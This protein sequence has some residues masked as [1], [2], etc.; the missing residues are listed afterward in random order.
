MKRTRLTLAEN[1]DY[2]ENI[3]NFI[4][5][6][7]TG[8]VDNVYECVKKIYTLCKKTVLEKDGKILALFELKGE[9][10]KKI[11][12]LEFELSSLRSRANNESNKSDELEKS[13]IERNNLQ[14]RLIESEQSNI[15][16]EILLQ[17]SKEQVKILENEKTQIKYKLE[18]SNKNTT[19]MMQKNVKIIEDKETEIKLLKNDIIGRENE[20]KTLKKKLEEKERD[21]QSLIQGS[22]LKYKEIE[23]LKMNLTLIE[24]NY[25]SQTIVLDKIKQKTL[26]DQETLQQKGKEISHLKKV[27]EKV[28]TKFQEDRNIMRD[29]ISQKEQNSKDGRAK[30]KTLYEE[31]KKLNHEIVETTDKLENEKKLLEDEKKLSSEYYMKLMEND[32]TISQLNQDVSNSRMEMLNISE[33]FTKNINAKEETINNLQ[34][35]VD[36]HYKNLEIVTKK[37]ERRKDH[38]KELEKKSSEKRTRVKKLEK[39]VSKQRSIITEFRDIFEKQRQKQHNALTVKSL[40]VLMD[41][42]NRLSEK[43]SK[44]SSKHSAFKEKRGEIDNQDNAKKDIPN[45]LPDLEDPTADNLCQDKNDDITCIEVDDKNEKSIVESEK[46]SNFSKCVEETINA[47]IV[48]KIYSRVFDEVLFDFSEEVLESEKQTSFIVSNLVSEL[49]DQVIEISASNKTFDQ[50]VVKIVKD[51]LKRFYDKDK[52]APNIKIKSREQFIGHCRKFSKESRPK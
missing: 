4:K 48:D 28:S 25:Q 37:L 50:S 16:V 1:N 43:L 8:D 20:F 39:E 30:L 12:N 7:I 41:G 23:N 49:L 3:V 42:Y 45:N 24:K 17:K 46:G 18:E 44:K 15:K 34:N 31:N 5:N 51:S 40:Q 52:S 11:E 29:L 6:A 19:W 14:N 33:K 36:N 22:Q 21:N 13:L 9:Y 10:E 2:S 27:L 35:V 26:S 47:Q 38:V 32:L